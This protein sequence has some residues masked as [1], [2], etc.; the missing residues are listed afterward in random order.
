MD[1]DWDLAY[2]TAFTILREAGPLSDE[3]WVDRIVE[4][5]F[6]DDTAAAVVYDNDDPFHV[7]TGDGENVHV[8]AHVEQGAF[9][10]RLGA[11]E[12]AADVVVDTPDLYPL[13]A[14]GAVDTLTPGIDAADRAE[15]TARGVEDLAPIMIALPRGT[16]AGFAPGDLVT[17]RSVS[18]DD[19]T[20][21]VAA[22][23]EPVELDLAPLLADLIDDDPDDVFGHA[24]TY[25]DP[26]WDTVLDHGYG[27]VPTL[28]FTEL[29]TRAGY[30]IDDDL[31][32]PEGFDFDGYRA[33]LGA[34]TSADA[35]GL[36]SVEAAAVD[37]FFL[38]SLG[39]SDPARS[40][41]EVL[42]EHPTVFDVFDTPRVLFAVVDEMH[43]RVLSGVSPEIDPETAQ[44]LI[45][46]GYDFCGA[47]A[48]AIARHAP[49]VARPG[50]L[51]V[52]A[53]AA[54]GTGRLDRA[55][56][57]W[58]DILKLDRTWWPALR[59]LSIVALLR[60]DHARALSLVRE[61]PDSPA[62]LIDDLQTIVRG[63][64]PEPGRNEPCPC[65]SGRK[66]KVCH[67]GRPQVP[68]EI[69]NRL[70]VVNALDFA[71]LS[72][73]AVMLDMFHE[74]YLQYADEETAERFAGSPLPDD[75]ALVEGGLFEVQL[76]VAGLVMPEEDRATVERW[77]RDGRSVYEVDA[78][79][80]GEGMTLRDLR[81][82]ERVDV[83]EVLGSR[84]V[85]EG[86]RLCSRVVVEGDVHVLYG[87]IEPVEPD[88]C[89][90]LI[91]ILEAGDPIALLDRFARRLG[92]E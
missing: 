66:F 49:T 34:I 50:A 20:V 83:S 52:L 51:Y 1:D 10:H 59:A 58:H 26:L 4:A 84:T 53:S 45:N 75:V 42:A 72:S 44:T 89:P 91:E 43:I 28:P 38:V 79:R 36:G 9:P 39:S 33:E 18:I 6:D 56:M 31:L 46:A 86:V 81:S 30:V 87:G 40:V 65:G 3:D 2:D 62:G 17:V 29:V 21:A 11:A 32:A 60:G 54:L 92:P 69:R 73:G 27:T 77:I 16:L 70:L 35:L 61:V 47:A 24:V 78:V 12:I 71:G 88:D 15:A 80:P 57:A 82:G 85:P 19:G 48:A 64:G 90:E 55:E 76:A 37:T 68:P 14:T 8:R 25:M 63:A 7:L 5:G 67:R 23:G 41:A 74:H 22:A 13:T